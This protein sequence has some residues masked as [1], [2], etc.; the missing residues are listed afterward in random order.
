MPTTLSGMLVLSVFPLL[1]VAAG[2]GDFLTFRIP[3]WLNAALVVSFVAMVFIAGMPFEVVK[4]HLL[5]AAI[6]LAGGMILFFTIEFGG[7]DAKM[8]AASALWIGWT[9]LLNFL[10]Y[11]ALA[12]GG[13]AALVIIRRRIGQERDF[14][15]AVRFRSLFN[16]EVKV[17]YGVAIAIGGILVYSE[18]WWMKYVI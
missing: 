8:L 3:N 1:L 7:G 15:G 10:L 11:T 4:W 9:P 17:P 2:I 13:L 12:G 18:T 5:A 14:R 6:V 16:K